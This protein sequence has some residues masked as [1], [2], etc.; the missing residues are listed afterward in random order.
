MIRL[1]YKKKIYGDKTMPKSYKDICPCK[2]CKNRKED[3]HS[4]CDKYKEWKDSGEEIPPFPFIDYRKWG[5]R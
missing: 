5:K 1:W 3:C 2:E 4:V